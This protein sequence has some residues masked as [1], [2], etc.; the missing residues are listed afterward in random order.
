MKFKK[1][2]ILM[3]V[4]LV[5]LASCEEDNSETPPEVETS[6]TITFNVKA[7]FAG[8]EFVRGNRYN[9]NSNYTVSIDNLKFYL[10]NIYA[11]K[12]NGDSILLSEVELFDFEINDTTFTAALPEADYQGIAFCIGVPPSLNSPSNPNFLI[13]VYDENS[14][15]SA[16]NGT[17]WGWLTGYRFF[18]FDGRY[19]LIPNSIDP[20]LEGFSFHT[21][22]DTVFKSVDLVSTPFVIASNQN[23]SFSVDFDVSKF[24]YSSSNTIDLANESDYHGDLNNVYLAIDLTN[25]IANSIQYQA[26]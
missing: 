15:L 23:K 6:S 20:I 10:S 8:N 11:I 13:S 4:L 16:L 19:D 7:N 18:M 1:Y 22:Q 26:E 12:Q 9:N 14:A 17:Y 25:N 2:N 24:F 5:A 3:V 21:G